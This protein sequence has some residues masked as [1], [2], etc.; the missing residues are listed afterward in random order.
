MFENKKILK[1]IFV[2]LLSSFQFSVAAP[3]PVPSP[4]QVAAKNYLLI[5][6]VHYEYFDSFHMV[7]DW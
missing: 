3:V 4:P 7:S 5:D 6:L 1:F 2:L